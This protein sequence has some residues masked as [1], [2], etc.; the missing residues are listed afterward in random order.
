[1]AKANPKVFGIDYANTI[2]MGVDLLNEDIQNLKEAKRYLEPFK[3]SNIPK[4]KFLLSVIKKLESK[5]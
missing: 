3:D 4:V 2:V 5:K 1:M